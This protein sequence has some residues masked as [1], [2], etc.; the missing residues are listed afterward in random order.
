VIVRKVTTVLG[1][2]A[3]L[4]GLAGLAASSRHAVEVLVVVTAFLWL[5]G[6][7]WHVLSIGSQP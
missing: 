5:T 6:T 1:V 3:G 4:A 7:I 2:I